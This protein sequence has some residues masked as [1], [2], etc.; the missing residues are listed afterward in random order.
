MTTQ[1]IQ[2]I[3]IESFLNQ[4]QRMWMNA[5]NVELQADKQIKI[6]DDS[7]SIGDYFF[8][9]NRIPKLF[10]M[11]DKKIE[12]SLKGPVDD[13]VIHITEYLLK[14]RKKLDVSIIN[15][16]IISFKHKI[17]PYTFKQFCGKIS[18]ITKSG[19]IAEESY[20][21]D[22]LATIYF[23]DKAINKEPKKDDIVCAGLAVR[24]TIEGLIDLY[25]FSFRMWCSNGAI[26]RID[27]QNSRWSFQFNGGG[28]ELGERFFNDVKNKYEATGIQ[29]LEHIA[30]LKNKTVETSNITGFL[31][32]MVGPQQSLPRREIDLILKN[33]KSEK[34]M[35][36]YDF[37]N[38][39]TERLTYRALK[40]PERGFRYF[41]FGGAIGDYI[42]DTFGPVRCKSCGT[43]FG[44]IEGRNLH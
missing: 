15:N 13:L 3:T 36:A 8:K 37:W 35:S 6:C 43:P 10:K 7:L 11:L 30:S 26:H 38:N 9:T 2:A 19:L 28:E 17:F 21:G 33:L 12:I 20:V 23:I 32:Q 42:G 18:S 39:I 40:N 22:D 29:T 25:P 24:A 41:N 16:E 1:K 4:H 34:E 44:A 5:E 27:D 31:R 14:K